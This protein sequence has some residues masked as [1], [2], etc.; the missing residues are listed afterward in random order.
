[1]SLAT[2]SDPYAQDGPYA[3]FRLAISILL[4][5]LGGAGMWAVVIVLPA[6]QSDFGIDRADASLPYTATMFGFAAGNYLLGRFVD[7][8]GIVLPVIGSALSLS[9]GFVLAA[10]APDVWSFSLAQGVL[11]GL[12]TAA[13]FGPLI[14]DISHWFL[15]RRGF[16]VACAAC[17]NYLAGVLWPSLIQWSL[18]TTDWRHTYILIGVI[19]LVA[20]VPLALLLRRPPP[21][22]SLSAASATARFGRQDTGLPPAVLQALLVV[23]GLACCV[24]MSMPQVHIVAYCVDLG[25]GVAPGAD[26]IALMTGAGVVS[27]LTSG[28][29]ADKI[30]GVMTLL[31]GSVLQCAALFLFIPF[32]GL[33][34]LYLVSLIFGLSQGGIVPSYAVI[35][36]EYLPAR[37][38]GQRV[39]LVIMS[40]ILG[41]ALGGWLSGW[42]YDLT[43]SYQAAFLNGIAWN[44]LNMAVMIF[45]FMRGKMRPT[46][47]AA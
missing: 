47:A 8:Y 5:T 10:F 36:R 19:C 13:T 11:I 33:A 27:R 41:M 3:W 16:A 28:Y 39:G 14:A 18:A 40:T 6:V 29:I 46:G 12:G 37:E 31:I 43:G 45:I 23:A 20:M 15:K 34:S 9:A 17:G 35:V 25:Y 7:R 38:A 21:D 30:G 44:F 42:I 22:T 24:A 4:S 32:N 2:A 26:M 1:M